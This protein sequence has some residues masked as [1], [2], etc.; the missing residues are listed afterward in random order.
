MNN[1]KYLELSNYL[2][3]II[4]IFM[5][6]N[7]SRYFSQRWDDSR[8]SYLLMNI[9]L[10]ESLIALLPRISDGS[11]SDT[12]VDMQIKRRRLMTQPGVLS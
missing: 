4:F 3:C 6:C 8:S 5:V 1:N 11:K 10:V 7:D 2:L 9:F 12:G